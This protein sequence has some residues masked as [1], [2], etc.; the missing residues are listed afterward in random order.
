MLDRHPARRR[1]DT[2]AELHSTRQ[3]RAYATQGRR[4]VI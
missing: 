2:I 4:L 3:D 1:F